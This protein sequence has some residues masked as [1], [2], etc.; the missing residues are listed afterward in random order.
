[1]ETYILWNV[2]TLMVVYKV[3]KEV[4]KFCVLHGI[5][6]MHSVIL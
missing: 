2:V 4:N 1:M 3:S 6:F 5:F